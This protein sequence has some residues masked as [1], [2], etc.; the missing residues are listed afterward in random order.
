M[1]RVEIRVR[2]ENLSTSRLAT[3][4]PTGTGIPGERPPDRYLSYGVSS[5]LIV[6][7]AHGHDAVAAGQLTQWHPAQALFTRYILLLH[8]VRVQRRQKSLIRT[9]SLHMAHY[10]LLM[11]HTARSVLLPRFPGSQLPADFSA[12]F[13]LAD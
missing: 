3:P 5:K 11:V 4:G 8:H 10:R 12:G 1:S 6:A 13:F 7:P 9:E 2:P